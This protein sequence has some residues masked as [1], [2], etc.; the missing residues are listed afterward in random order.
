MLLLLLLLFR[1]LLAW[2]GTRKEA[3]TAGKIRTV[4]RRLAKEI[5]VRKK[6]ECELIAAQNDLLHAGRLT[7][8]GQMAASLVH[9]LSQPVTSMIMLTSSCRRMAR[10]GQ[11]SKITETV[12]NLSA[13]VQRIWALIEQLRLFSRKSPARA[14][15]VVRLQ[16][17]LDN[18]L[19]VLRC[20]QKD[21]DCLLTVSC[22][23]DVMVV[24]EALQL[25]QALI[26]LIH[27]ALDAVS[28]V[29]AQERERRVA[30]RVTVEKEAVLLSVE[31]NG[32]G[33]P[34]AVRK[35]IF[36]PF[37][38]TKKSG[39]GIGLGLAI[40]DNIARSMNCS[41]ETHDNSPHG[42]CFTLRLRPTSKNGVS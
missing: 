4:N 27:N 29:S 17:T 12:E 34:P 15:S 21:A 38:T 7:A 24:G 40:V 23:P 39:E 33:I 32:P 5:R 1:I 2:S 14:M 30:I 42:A 20:K 36:T 31:D 26:N 41:V 35:E 22:P 28:A 16:D 18:A 10:D 9:E 37:F 8:L 11:N 3:A 13:L 6:T 19:A 25:E